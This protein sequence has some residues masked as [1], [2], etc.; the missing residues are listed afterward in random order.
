MGSELS[1]NKNVGAE[2]RS[3]GRF[4]AAFPRTN[5]AHILGFEKFNYDES[6]LY[7]FDSV[8]CEQMAQACSNAWF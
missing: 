6:R 2:P 3:P 1:A 4:S 5:V 8:S 7:S